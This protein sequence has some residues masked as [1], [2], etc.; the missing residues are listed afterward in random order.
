MSS[1]KYSEYPIPCETCQTYTLH[2]G[3]V[4]G[5]EYCI[6]HERPGEVIVAKMDL[7]E[8]LF[9]TLQY[10]TLKY[11][12]DSKKKMNYGPEAMWN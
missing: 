3:P 1:L 8:F 4:T 7:G 6:R 10:E 11:I 2:Y 5:N 9:Q 12:R